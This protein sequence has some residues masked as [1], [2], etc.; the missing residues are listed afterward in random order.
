MA[1]A[2]F[3][4]AKDKMHKAAENLQRNLGQIR[5]GRA[6]ASL[7]DLLTNSNF[8]SFSYNSFI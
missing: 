8:I 6:N 4:E 5:A 1:D 7:L 3:N 2:I